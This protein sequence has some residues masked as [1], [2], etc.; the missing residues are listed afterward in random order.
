M[1]D[2]L[3]VPAEHRVGDVLLF[4]ELR[5]DQSRPRLSRNDVISGIHY[6]GVAV[7]CEFSKT[8]YL[9]CIPSKLHVQKCIKAKYSASP[10]GFLAFFHFGRWC[11]VLD[12][13]WIC[14]ETNT[15]ETE[16]ETE[17]QKWNGMPIGNVQE[18]TYW[19]FVATSIMECWRIS[20]I[21]SMPKIIA[22][23]WCQKTKKNYF[24]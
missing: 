9:N 19:S 7:F 2:L 24:Y 16:F 1:I 21:Q 4:V 5:S 13:S 12:D 6:S 8:A 17:V 11:R 20:D 23:R 18:R 14:L 3:C 22:D 10:N 15:K